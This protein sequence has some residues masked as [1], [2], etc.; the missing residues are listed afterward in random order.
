M[1][2]ITVLPFAPVSSPKQI[3]LPK[4]SVKVTWVSK[5]DV[6]DIGMVA[7]VRE[8]PNNLFGAIPVIVICEFATPKTQINNKVNSFLRIMSFR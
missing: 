5:T 4:K 7:P 8:R 3:L 2:E 6:S 1:P